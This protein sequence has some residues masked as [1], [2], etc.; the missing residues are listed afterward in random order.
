MPTVLREGPY[1]FFFYSAVAAEP[2]HNHVERDVSKAKL[3]LDPT[4]LENDRGF[5]RI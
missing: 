5:G 4:R 3:W 1:R 2:P